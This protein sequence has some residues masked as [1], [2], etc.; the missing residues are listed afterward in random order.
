[1]V[2]A[3]I[4][5]AIVVATLV[6][7]FRRRSRVLGGEPS[8]WLGPIFRYELL[9]IARRGQQSRLRCLYGS[10]LLTGLTIAFSNQ[11]DLSSHLFN[12]S[13]R[14][15][16]NL[17]ID[18]LAQFAENFLVVF[19]VLQALAVIVL[20][21]AIVGGAIGEDKERG[22]FDYLLTSPLSN[23]EIVLGKWSAR[24]V[25][26][27]SV[28]LTGLPILSMTLFFGGVD[29]GLLLC[30]FGVA[31]LG[32]FSLGAYCILMSVYR[33]GLKEVLLN[34]YLNITILTIF[35]L[36]CGMIPGLAAGSPLATVV[37]MF[38]TW[39]K[40]NQ[41]L[42][43]WTLGSY[44]LLHGFVTILFLILAVRAVRQPP[45]R[46]F[47]QRFSLTAGP[48]AVISRLPANES[49]TTLVRMDDAGDN[50]SVPPVAVAKPVDR[51][52]R[53]DQYLV[54]K[55]HGRRS[56]SRSF[57]VRPLNDADNPLFWKERHFTGRLAMVEKSLL[58]SFSAMVIWFFACVIVCTVALSVIASLETGRWHGE[59]LN[60]LFR[61]LVI[62]V[63]L[64]LIVLGSI[65]AAGTVGRERQRR[66]LDSL[67]MLPVA[68]KAILSAKWW[69]IAYSLKY[70]ILA[71]A[72]I[73]GL[74]VLFKALHPLGAIFALV[75]ALAYLFFMIH[76]GLWLS[77][78]CSTVPRATTWLM[79]ITL[80]IWIGL[81]ILVSM[82]AST[83]DW[84]MLVSVSP[85]IGLWLLSLPW[86]LSGWSAYEAELIW[87]CG[88]I[89]GS[90]YLVAGYC[91]WR[92]GVRHFNGEG[93]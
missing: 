86:S 42:L 90:A 15:N 6:V 39:E 54:L 87:T 61:C 30:G 68:R 36:C 74:G 83:F 44:I 31:L 3:G 67:L 89:Y 82:A 50:P 33:E 8:P 38:S 48:E 7:V 27:A 22:T 58:V 18:R 64:W 93:R 5:T 81:P 53:S 71:I 85:P 46:W 88:F 41:E 4:L 91:L 23:R 77:I 65:R 37:W 20:T 35:G 63:T 60:P 28:L 80:G 17:P 72:I 49:A 10:L 40:S 32:M 70:S 24:L 79:V 19:L 75:Y 66:T 62:G 1:M 78:R 45:R 52:S 92:A 56:V 25:I 47:R 13:D 26:V 43:W 21:P 29:G 16:V 73:L 57:G 76:L 2:I 12:L 59:E 9:R 14:S 69:A 34:A 11:F 55:Q 84:V 51:D